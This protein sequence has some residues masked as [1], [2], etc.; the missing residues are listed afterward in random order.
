M[1]EKTTDSICYDAGTGILF[2]SFKYVR[3]DYAADMERMRSNPKVRE[4]WRMTD[5]WQ[6]SLVEGATSSEAGEPDWWK[7]IEEVF[8]LA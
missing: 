5:S 7:P 3:Y 4:W 8:Y 6:E 2:S 1:M